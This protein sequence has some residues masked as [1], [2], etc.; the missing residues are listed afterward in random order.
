MEIRR[1]T[2]QEMIDYKKEI[3]GFFKKNIDKYP[4]CVDDPIRWYDNCLNELFQLWG[5]FNS[6][7]DGVFL[8]VVDG[9]CVNAFALTG[10]DVLKYIEHVPNILTD[11]ANACGV[12][13]IQILSSPA[14]ARAV[15]GK[16]DQRPLVLV[17]LDVW[18]KISG[19]Q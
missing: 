10:K 6:K 12:R 13:Y 9:N 4:P 5:F 8:T 7:L 2:L 16:F 11:F 19:K 1:L 3:I 18:E 14:L 17:T 15:Y